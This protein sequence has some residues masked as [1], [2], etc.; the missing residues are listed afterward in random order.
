MVK[1]PNMDGLIAELPPDS[2]EVK[3]L[4]EGKAYHIIPL[5]RMAEA[6][7][8]APAMLFLV[9]DDSSYMTGSIMVVD[10]GYS[11]Q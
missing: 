8:V 6:D 3:A 10:G 4:K 7:E 2:V 5:G 11:A 1:T 9:S